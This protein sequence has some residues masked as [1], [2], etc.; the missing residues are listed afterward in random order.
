MLLCIVS[1]SLLPDCVA[2][3]SPSFVRVQFRLSAD[4]L[5][6]NPLELS[7]GEESVA[8]QIANSAANQ[9][10]QFS[11]DESLMVAV[12]ARA[13]AEAM[14]ALAASDLAGAQSQS[15]QSQSPAKAQSRS[16]AQSLWRA[17]S[18]AGL[19]L[20][21]AQTT[22]ARFASDLAAALATLEESAAKEFDPDWMQ[23]SSGEI[24]I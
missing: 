17:K 19:A 15:A 14:A 11:V 6:Q 18:A 7:L 23:A 8:H 13:F 21:R 12:D 5:Q 1:S 10:Q 3:L 2:L 9:L 24:F 16:P 4:F 20:A 22:S